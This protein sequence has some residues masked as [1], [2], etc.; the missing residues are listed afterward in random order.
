MAKSHLMSSPETSWVIIAG[1][2]DPHDLRDVEMSVRVLQLAGVLNTQITV[3]LSLNNAKL[4]ENDTPAFLEK[5]S[6]VRIFSSEE[7]IKCF[8]FGKKHVVIVAGHGGEGEIACYPPMKPAGFLDL[9][10]SKC[11]EAGLLI[12]SQCFSGIFNYL[13]VTS[14]ER[15]DSF[16]PEFT[17]SRNPAGFI[18]G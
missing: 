9:I 6:S 10:N 16:G 12:F 13:P 1:H 2:C 4:S 15:G 5:I 3:F 14:L 11:S 7:V 8:P 18:G 17:K